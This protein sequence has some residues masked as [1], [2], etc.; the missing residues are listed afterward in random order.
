MDDAEFI[1]DASDSPSEDTDVERTNASFAPLAQPSGAQQ[2]HHGNSRNLRFSC[3]ECGVSCA[4]RDGLYRHRRVKHH[5]GVQYSCQEPHCHKK[6]KQWGRFDAF[7]KHMKRHHNK[8]IFYQHTDSFGRA[9]PPT[10]DDPSPSVIESESSRTVAT[11]EMPVSNSWDSEMP[12]IVQPRGDEHK[13]EP[14]FATG[15]LPGLD[16]YDRGQLIQLIGAKTREC[17]ELRRQCETLRNDRDEKARQCGEFREKCQIVKM[18][19]D[20]YLEALTMSEE[21]RKTLE[22]KGCP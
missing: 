12:P 22:A 19:R 20:E 2:Q 11:P 17:D 3:P 18:E 21:M 5:I 15:T 8:S 1:D 16:S 10:P 7:K 14:S 6:D 13:P 4:R 9:V